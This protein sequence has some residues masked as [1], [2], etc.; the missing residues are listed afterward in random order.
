MR[1]P[2]PSTRSVTP[3]RSGATSWTLRAKKS[4]PSTG[5][6]TDERGDGESDEEGTGDAS[7]P[8]GDDR[9]AEAG[10]RR[11]DAGLD[12]A[13]RGRCGDLR[14]LDSGHAPADVVGSDGPENRPAQDGADVVRGAGGREQQQREPE[15]AGEAEC[16]DRDSQA[17]ATHLADPAREE[18][19][20]ERARVRGGVEQAGH[21]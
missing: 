10:E 4:V 21:A 6:V 18:R 13:E 19:R 16:G 3:I 11:E 7:E 5:V 14:E 2:M 17:L 20:D 1:P 8:A 9:E 12:V 15:T